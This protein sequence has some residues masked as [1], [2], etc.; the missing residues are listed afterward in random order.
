MW[1]T[2]NLFYPHGHRS[3]TTPKFHGVEQFFR[4]AGE[5]FY[6]TSC[7]TL[8][9]PAVEAKPI[10]AVAYP[11]Q[12][13]RIAHIAGKPEQFRLSI[14]HVAFIILDYLNLRNRRVASNRF[15]RSC[16][17]SSVVSQIDF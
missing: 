7:T 9:H 16:I 14:S 3:Q 5:R 13:I 11:V 4:A 6:G 12:K 2:F 17:R 15:S 1:T 10:G 8:T